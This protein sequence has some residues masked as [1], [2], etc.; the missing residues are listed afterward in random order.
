MSQS[1]IITGDELEMTSKQ[2]TFA[3]ALSREMIP[4]ARIMVFFIRQPEEVVADVLNFYVDGIAQK[5]VRYR[6]IVI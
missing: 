1:N 4:T 3:I 6:F 2:K 5:K